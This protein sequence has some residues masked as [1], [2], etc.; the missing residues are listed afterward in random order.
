M[1]T[2]DE[3]EFYNR[4]PYLVYI[5]K[6]LQRTNDEEMKRFIFKMLRDI[7]EIIENP[8]LYFSQYNIQLTGQSF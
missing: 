4:L 5:N 8:E 2:K 1:R 3:E 7:D 6:L